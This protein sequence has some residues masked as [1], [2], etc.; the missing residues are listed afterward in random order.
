ME[1]ENVYQAFDW[2]WCSAQLTEADI[3]KLSELGIEAVINLAPSTASN[4]LPGEAELVVNQGITYIQIP[5]AWEQPRLSQLEQFFA[6]LKAFK[7]HKVWVHCAKNKRASAFIYLYRKLCLAE[8]EVIAL[9][10]MSEIWTPNPVWQAFIDYAIRHIKG[11][12][13]HD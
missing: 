3:A 8:E 1:A 7:R 12:S 4:A 2:L 5:V 11:P 9:Y 6:V 13:A 10:P